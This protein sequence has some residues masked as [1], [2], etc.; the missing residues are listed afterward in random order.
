MV[1][2]N[3]NAGNAFVNSDPKEITRGNFVGLLV[4]LVSVMPMVEF[5]LIMEPAIVANAFAIPATK[6]PTVAAKLIT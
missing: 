5:A 2:V 3:A 4:L 1:T 6:A